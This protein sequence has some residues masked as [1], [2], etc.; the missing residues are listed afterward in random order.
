MIEFT[1]CNEA[2]SIKYSPAKPYL[3]VIGTFDGPQ[4][5]DLRNRKYI[6]YDIDL[7]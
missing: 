7:I 6:T 4:I 3:F 2:G 5:Y 1:G